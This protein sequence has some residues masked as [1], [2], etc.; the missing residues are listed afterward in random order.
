MMERDALLAANAAYYRAFRMGDFPAMRAL[1][2]EEGVACIHP[3][4]P[5]L[6]G[7]EA[8][9]ES[10]RRILANPGQEPVVASAESVL[11][12]G[13]VARVLCIETV[14]GATLAAT[15]FF[16]RVGEVWRMVHHQA[17]PVAIPMEK[18]ARGRLN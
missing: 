15:N 2:A 9:L 16:V 18:P 7:R 12:T 8:V 1:W 13:D 11:V 5:A 3:G 6:E 17:S 14:A 10:Y 4:W